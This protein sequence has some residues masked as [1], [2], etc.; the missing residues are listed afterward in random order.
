[1]KVTFRVLCAVGYTLYGAV[2]PPHDRSDVTTTAT[3]AAAAATKHP[4]I[5]YVYG[6]PVVQV[7]MFHFTSFYTQ[8]SIF[9]R[10]GRPE[11]STARDCELPVTPN[12]IHFDGEVPEIRRMASRF[13]RKH[14][15]G[16]VIISTG[17]RP[18]GAW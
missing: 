13:Q 9:G 14:D 11:S 17:T 1:M 12:H 2:H 4:T 7:S 8:T 3:A 18:K 16:V 15:K 10:S 6:G 5:V